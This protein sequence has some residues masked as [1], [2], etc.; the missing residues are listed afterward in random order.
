M[1][2]R[3]PKTDY[4]DPLLRKTLLALAVNLEKT[5]TNVPKLSQ[6]KLATLAGIASST[7]SEIERG[8]VVDL[9]LST[10]TA[11]AGILEVDPLRLLKINEELIRKFLTSK[12]SRKQK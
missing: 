1:A 2:R 8:D 5:R 12:A 7:V 3:P 6:Q 10:L 9:R 11:L 4:R